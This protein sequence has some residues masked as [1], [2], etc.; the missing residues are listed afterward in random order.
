MKYPGKT[1]ILRIEKEHSWHPFTQMKDYAN[2]NPLVIT[3]ANGLILI[4]ADGN[5]YYDTVSSW[6]TN[7]LGHRRPEITAAVQEQAGKLEHVLY[8]GITHPGAAAVMAEL[9]SLLDPTLCRCFFSD[10]GSTAVEVALKMAFQHW[11]NLGRTAKKRFAML[12][13]AYHGDTLGAVSVGGVDLFHKIYKPLLFETLQAS[14]PDCRS[15]PHRKSQFTLDA[16]DTGCSIE[17]FASMEQ[18]LKEH[19]QELAAVI[20]EPLILAAGGLLVYPPEYLNRLFKLAKE[21]DILVIF[22]EVA[23]GFGR[24]GTLFAYQQTKGIPDLICFSK[25]LTG[26]YL[27]MAMTVATEN[28]FQS[29][30]S[31]DRN[32][33]FFHGHSY[34]ANPL[35]CAASAATLKLLRQENLPESNLAN[36]RLF[37]TEIMKFADLRGVSD[38]R[39][40]GWIGC[41]DLCGPDR[42]GTKPLSIIHMQEIYRRGQQAGLILRPLG[43][44]IYWWLPLVTTSEAVKEIMQ[45]SY[46]VVK[47]VLHEAYNN[48]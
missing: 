27:P 24:T 8:A 40:L 38:I 17:C 2:S 5:E 23:T 22:D 6:W 36:C 4:D 35:C 32:K 18:I 30:Y 33:T 12:K 10:D 28:I 11:H 44:S 9:T 34:T 37:Q 42:D 7:I 48:N 20:V 19:H 14:T 1:E 45:R 31:S 39:Y 47:D 16:R 46:E 21:L 3:E 43:N 13:N 41:I 25:G 15:C 26:G 29:F